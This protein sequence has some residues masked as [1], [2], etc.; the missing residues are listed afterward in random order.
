VGTSTPKDQRAKLREAFRM[1]FPDIGE[2]ST[3]V[4]NRSAVS[5][6]KADLSA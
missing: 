3:V 6:E 4:F 1:W 2:W 5:M